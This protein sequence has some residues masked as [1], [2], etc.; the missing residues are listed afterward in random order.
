MKRSLLLNIGIAAL[1]IIFLGGAYLSFKSGKPARVLPVYGPA[2]HAVRDFHLVDQTGRNI[3][4]AAFSG[5][6]YVT[7]FF[8]TTC[9]SICPIMSGKMET[10]YNKYKGNGTVMFLSHTVNPENDNVNVL[11]DYAKQH[12]ADASQWC[13]VTGDKKE[14]YDLA[15]KS[16]FLD[17]AEGSGGPD[18]F[19]HTPQF[20][21]VDK[22]KRIRGYYNGTDSAE[23]AKL[24]VDIDLLLAQYK[25]EEK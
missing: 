8:F 20:V 23:V 11:A 2:G 24:M 13:F 17:A 10:V 9:Q 15:R 21:L 7:D 4:Q 22:E 18:D 5:K 1:A 14:L 25:Y 19:I 6:I 16:Y 12:H 3:S